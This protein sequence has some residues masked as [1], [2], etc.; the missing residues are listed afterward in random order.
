MPAGVEAVKLRDGY[1]QAKVLSLRTL[2]KFGRIRPVARPI[3]K[4]LYTLTHNET[5]WRIIEARAEDQ[6]ELW[7]LLDML[8]QTGF[9][10][11]RLWKAHPGERESICWIVPPESFRM[12]SISS[13]ME[14]PAA[15]SAAE[16]HLTVR[17]PDVPD[18]RR[19][20]YRWLAPAHGT[21]SNFL[22]RMAETSAARVEPD[23]DQ[24]WSTRPA[25][26]CPAMSPGRSSCSPAAPAWRPFVACSGSAPGRRK[27]GEN[28]LFFGTRTRADLVLST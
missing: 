23:Y 10:P 17:A 13:A 9:N 24:D 1:Q 8:A 19:P 25:S 2:L 12:Y 7:E 27:Q 11:K 26:A 22:A 20:L 5:L 14:D 3:A 28:W 6:W 18:Y 4:A 15:E 21:G 16:I